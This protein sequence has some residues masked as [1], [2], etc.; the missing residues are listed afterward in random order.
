MNLFGVIT[1]I[2]QI[3]SN[4][5][6]TT[7]KM[8]C[9]HVNLR[10]C[11][12]VACCFGCRGQPPFK[13]APGGVKYHKVTCFLNVWSMVLPLFSSW[14]YTE[15]A[16]FLPNTL[17]PWKKH[18]LFINNFDMTPI[19]LKTMTPWSLEFNQQPSTKFF[20]FCSFFTWDRCPNGPCIALH[21]A[22]K[23]VQFLIHGEG[24]MQWMRHGELVRLL[25]LLSKNCLGYT[26]KCV[27]YFPFKG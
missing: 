13:A 21:S 14:E 25:G 11:I 27:F 6:C 7:P 16:V 10:S 19:P 4:T 9:A 2:F 18:C 20:S 12:A 26:K 15:M 5:F 17:G 23:Q 22:S 8:T 1:Y 24:D 3:V